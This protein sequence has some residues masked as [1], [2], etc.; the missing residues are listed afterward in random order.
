MWVAIHL[1]YKVVCLIKAFIEWKLDAVFDKISGIS[2]CA[3]D[4][5]CQS[6]SRIFDLTLNDFSENYHELIILQDTTIKTFHVN[7]WS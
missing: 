1:F 3:F 4:E 2:D 7:I 5:S 6:A